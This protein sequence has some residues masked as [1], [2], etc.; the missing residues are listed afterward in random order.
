[1]QIW[2][3]ALER[4]LLSLGIDA[5]LISPRPVF[6]RFKPSLPASVSGSAISTAICSFRLF[7]AQRTAKAD[8]VHMCDHG[9]A[10]YCSKVNGTPVVVTR[11]HMLAVRGALGELPE[12]AS[13]RL[14]RYFQLWICKGLRR[15]TRVACIS[16]ATYDDAARILGRRDHLR[17]VLDALN[18]PEPAAI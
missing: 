8:I 16:Q 13:S 18:Y 2:A 4:D 14:G 12:M 17:V 6:G 1:M 3:R 11:N 15:A 10:M 7:C 5:T 9:S